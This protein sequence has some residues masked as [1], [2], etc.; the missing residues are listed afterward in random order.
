MIWFDMKRIIS[1]LVLCFLPGLSLSQINLPQN[2]LDFVSSLNQGHNN[3]IVPY[4]SGEYN[5]VLDTLIT[6][7]DDITINFI[8]PDFSSEAQES[9]S[10]V[11]FDGVTFTSNDVDDQKKIIINLHHPAEINISNSSLINL[12]LLTIRYGKVTDLFIENNEPQLN[13]YNNRFIND[14]FTQSDY[15]N[16]IQIHRSNNTQPGDVVRIK[17]INIAHNEFLLK[18]PNR[19]NWSFE[20]FIQ[21]K[22]YSNAI[23]LHRR[24]NTDQVS[25]INIEHNKFYLNNTYDTRYEHAVAGIIFHNM[26][27]EANRENIEFLNFHNDGLFTYNSN[28]TID[29]NEFYTKAKYSRGA[30][31]LMGPYSEVKINENILK[32]FSR[33]MFRRDSQDSNKFVIHPFHSIVL[34]GARDVK[35][36]GSYSYDFKNVSI[37]R[38][39]IETKSAGIG[40]SGARDVVISENKIKLIKKRNYSIDFQLHEKEF[41]IIRDREAIGVRT[42]AVRDTNTISRRIEISNN[43]IDVN[44]QKSGQGINLRHVGSVDVL[45]N[46]IHN[47]SSF[48]IKHSS[49]SNVMASNRIELMR[50]IGNKITVNR[51]YS[52]LYTHRKAGLWAN[53]NDGNYVSRLPL[54]GIVFFRRIPEKNISDILSVNLSGKNESIIIEDNIISKRDLQTRSLFFENVVRVNGRNINL[55]EYA[56]ERNLDLNNFVNYKINLPTSIY[57]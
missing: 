55:I 27:P 12:E 54:G 33:Y 31:V 11:T 22:L 49:E 5:I 42:A 56:Q 34:Y 13:I 7:T 3:F 51:G 32:G 47:V 45:F 17:N 41:A 19:H 43:K 18:R 30:I 38:N 14:S 9:F 44:N 29:N 57:K 10:R 48:G 37:T 20:D 24:F 2:G 35:I 53:D 39:I 25:H 16:L 15:L 23:W 1:L 52:S 36:D 6:L 40:L 46:E 4:N 26:V 21:D 8:E 50:I 28:I